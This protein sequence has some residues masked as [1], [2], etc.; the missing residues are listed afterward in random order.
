MM[1][2]DGVKN[3]SMRG[4][5]IKSIQLKVSGKVESDSFNVS[6]GA[7]NVQVSVKALFTSVRKLECEIMERAKWETRKM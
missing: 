6:F 4:A 2:D 7:H 1:A 3:L 5:G